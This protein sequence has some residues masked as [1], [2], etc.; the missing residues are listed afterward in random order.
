MVELGALPQLI[1]LLDW[2]GVRGSSAQQTAM[3]ACNLLCLVAAEPA[4]KGAFLEDG[5]LQNRLA[6]LQS[7]T[8]CCA[9]NLDTYMLR[10]HMPMTTYDRLPRLLAQLAYICWLHAT[11][12]SCWSEIQ[13]HCAGR[14]SVHASTTELHAIAL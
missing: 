13:C 12:R 5:M 10:G 3:L 8:P 11:S 14:S 7:L 9:T 6:Q 4:C 2:S 1:A